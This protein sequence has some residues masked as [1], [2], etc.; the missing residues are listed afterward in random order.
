[1]EVD[2]I[3]ELYASIQS[4]GV[5]VAKPLTTE[6]WGMVEFGIRTPEGHRMISL[7]Q[8]R[9][10]NT[11]WQ[12]T[13]PAPLPRE[14]ATIPRAGV[15]SSGSSD[16]GGPFDGEHAHAL[17]WHFLLEAHRAGRSCLEALA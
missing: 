11:R 16:A 17:R 10:A 4:R 8:W 15:F 9:P 3:S 12:P 14:C 6:S 5:E 2:D 7:R 1:M 13:Q